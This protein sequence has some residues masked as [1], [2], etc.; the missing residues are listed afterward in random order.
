M[1][2]LFSAPLFIL[3][4]S[5]IFFFR[6]F[7]LN[8][9]LPISADTIIGLY[10]PFRDLYAKDYPNG[11]SYKNS[12]VTDPVRQ[13]YPWKNLTVWTEM[14]GTFPLWNPYSFSGTPLLGTLQ[15][16]SFYPLTLLLFFL[17]FSF[18]W[19]LLIISQQILAGIFIYYYLKNLKLSSF[20]SLFGSLTFLF[21]G[22]S[23]AWLEWGNILHVALWLPLVLLSIDKIFSS[24]ST[25][26]K[27]LWNIIFL[28]SLTVAFFAG[29]LQIFFCLCLV[30]FIYFL[31][32]W[33]QN[34]KN[35]SH[36]LFF[37]AILLGFL[38]LTAIQ[39]LPTSQ[40]IMQSAR[41]VDQ[42]NNWQQDGWFIPWQ[43]LIQFFAPDFFGNPTTLNYWGV[44]N[45]GE[46]IG[47]V[48]ITPFLLGFF[49]LFS[50]RDKKTIF[51]G[52][53]FLCSLIFAL[54]T[55]IAKLPYIFHVPFLATSQPTRLLFL[56]D[57]SL[58]VLAALGFDTL[59][60]QEKKRFLFYPLG[61]ILFVFL[62]LWFFI[63]FGYKW[64]PTITLQ[65]ILTAKRNLYLPTIIV[66]VSV[67]LLTACI[68][69]R[70]K[71]AYTMFL[72]LLLCITLFD[73][74]RFSDKFTPFTN[75]N[76][77]FPKT[78][79][80]SLLQRD[81]SQ[82]RI[83]T[84]DSRILPPNFSVMYGLQ[85]IDGYD[86]LFLKSYA[87]LIAASER[88]KP[89]IQPPFG[90]NRIITPH[91]VNSR[92]IDLLGVKYV[93]TFSD[94]STDKFTKV[95]QE[96]QTK[97][98]KNNK[99]LPRVFFVNDIRPVSSKQEAIEELF[100]KAIDLRT[101][102]IVKDGPSM[103]NFGDGFVGTIKY[104]ANNVFLQTENDQVGFLVFTDIYYPTWHVKI[105]SNE[106]VDCE[107]T[108]IY[109]TDF[110]FRGIIVPAGKHA[111][112]FYDRLL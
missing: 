44:W 7:F 81:K 2:K 73:L 56:T 110:T 77:L 82:F 66:I 41:D 8:D 74:L 70:N 57:F 25:K 18:G 51:F 62:G 92:I 1:K 16:A 47:Y 50:R 21:C 106:G 11:I 34:G 64:I 24:D 90:F 91:N 36:C 6:P 101:T 33:W 94:L 43:H 23:I 15:S 65:N 85:S 20:A 45:Y 79:T 42:L 3:I 105:C 71:K 60:R 27:I 40:F 52:S 4:L 38:L 98:Y 12:L 26:N 83:M 17:P 86:P 107:E 59:I 104:E 84:T 102:A 61:F 97:V 39:W 48:G 53:L 31:I 19:S 32:R 22:F 30:A 68:F 58:A 54:P 88:D 55:F 69:N 96:G 63:I 67:S 37:I 5:V 89:N 75:K 46:F 78:P 49:A 93:L 109:Q 111:I 80:I 28:F 100:D 112:V 87:E 99:A 35:L 13:Q 14:H 9:Q 10:H 103:G 76:Y 72:V 95:F 108:R 29:H